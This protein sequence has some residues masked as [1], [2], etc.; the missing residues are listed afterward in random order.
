MNVA[1]DA[2]KTMHNNDAYLGIYD[3]IG[4]NA[5]PDEIIRT[6]RQRGDLFIV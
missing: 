3:I 5:K 2:H 4:V 6:D 1:L